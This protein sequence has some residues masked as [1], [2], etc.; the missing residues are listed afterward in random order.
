MME[1]N[2]IKQRLGVMKEAL[3][4]IGFRSEEA[5]KQIT[6]L[7]ELILMTVLARVVRDK[8][9]T[10]LTPDN[11]EKFLTESYRPEELKLLV[12]EESG[13][14]VGEYLQT[15][16]SDLPEDKKQAFYSQIQ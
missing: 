12:D 8:N 11:L 6:E 7:G 3:L 15:I 14:V 10:N 13:K 1:E 2:E 9:A 16:T 5:E 4:T